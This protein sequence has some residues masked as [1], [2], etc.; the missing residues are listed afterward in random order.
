[1]IFYYIINNISKN[2]QGTLNEHWE[3]FMYVYMVLNGNFYFKFTK[4][5]I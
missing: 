4:C 2:E 1:M 3:N 5:N